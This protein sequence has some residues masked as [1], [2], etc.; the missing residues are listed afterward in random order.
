MSGEPGNRGD[1]GGGR[2]GPNAHDAHEMGRY[3]ALAQVGL[4]MVA[5]IVIGLILDNNL[6]WKPWGVVGGAVLG[7]VGGLAHL[8][9]LANR[10]DKNQNQK[11]P[12]SQRRSSR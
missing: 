10:L 4:E 12:P 9:L 11:D 2:G 8:V 1:G 7:L 5:P 6:G 3:F